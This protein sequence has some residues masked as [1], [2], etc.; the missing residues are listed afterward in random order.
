MQVKI[1]LLLPSSSLECMLQERYDL[2]GAVTFRGAEFDDYGDSVSL[3]FELDAEDSVKVVRNWDDDTFVEG[4]I[5]EA[6]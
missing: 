3:S 1:E 4:L 2:E 5:S 6:I